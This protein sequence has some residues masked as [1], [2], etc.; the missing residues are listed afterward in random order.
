[1]FIKLYCENPL[2]TNGDIVLISRSVNWVRNVWHNRENIA[3]V[4]LTYLYFFCC[5]ANSCIMVIGESISFWVVEV[6]IVK[7]VMGVVLYC[8]ALVL[9]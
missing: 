4:V 2:F 9:Y 8:L 7:Y 1:M 6:L 3:A 5:P